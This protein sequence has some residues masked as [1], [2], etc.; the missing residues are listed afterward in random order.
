MEICRERITRETLIAP[1]STMLTK[2]RF[3]ACR[4][5]TSMAWM[6]KHTPEMAMRQN[7]TVAGSMPSAKHTRD[8]GP[9]MAHARAASTQY[10][11]PSQKPRSLKLSFIN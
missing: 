9:M 3:P 11:V 10:T 4:P 8:T 6:R 1:N 5:P 7:A 2:S